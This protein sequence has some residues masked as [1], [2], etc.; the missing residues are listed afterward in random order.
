MIDGQSEQVLGL[1]YQ[2]C[3]YREET[4]NINRHGRQSRTRT[5]KKII[6]GKK[7]K[8]QYQTAWTLSITLLMCVTENRI[9]FN[10]WS[11]K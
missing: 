1:S 3:F 5:E 4:I 2:D 8:S 6:N 10:T 11:T 7:A 9:C